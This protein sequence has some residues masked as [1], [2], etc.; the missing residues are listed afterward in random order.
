MTYH[1]FSF[2]INPNNISTAAT[3]H[4]QWRSFIQTPTLSRAMQSH[5]ITLSTHID[6]KT[7]PT[8]STYHIVFLLF[9]LSLVLSRTSQLPH[10]LHFS[11]KVFYI[12][13]GNIKTL[14]ICHS[15]FIFFDELESFPFFPFPPTRG[16]L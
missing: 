14:P 5:A 9:L 16:I 12:I 7:N 10:F 8:V 4:I 13:T 15:L 11:C 6:T 1:I 2:Y 3:C